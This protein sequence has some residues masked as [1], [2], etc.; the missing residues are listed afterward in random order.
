MRPNL[1]RLAVALQFT[2]QNK[3]PFTLLELQA[4][5]HAPPAASDEHVSVSELADTLKVSRP[6]VSRA[7]NMLVNHGLVTR[8]DDPADRRRVVILGTL[9][10][11]RLL[12]S[13]DIAMEASP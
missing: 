13:L 11:R 6:A 9:A 2:R 8:T 3:I 7:V 4:L 1:T 12:T 10:A 5:L